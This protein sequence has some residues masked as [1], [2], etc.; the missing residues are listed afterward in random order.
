MI[1]TS[2]KYILVEASLLKS[3]LDRKRK[4]VKEIVCESFLVLPHIVE[5]H[6]Q[7]QNGNLKNIFPMQT[8]SIASP[9]RTIGGGRRVLSFV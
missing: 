3:A 4:K 1:D 6:L 8:T 7:L 5:M 9:E 2:K